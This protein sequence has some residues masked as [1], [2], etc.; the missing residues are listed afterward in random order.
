MTP[1]AS[2][3]KFAVWGQPIAHTLS[4]RIH[5]A[6][7]RARG[8]AYGYAA[9][10][11]APDGVGEACRRARAELRGVNV[12]RPL[13][14]VVMSCL[15]GV[16]EEAGLLG[17]VNVLFFRE[18]RLLGANTDGKGF[19]D[20]LGED[21]R[22]MRVLILGSGGAARAVGQALVG[23]GAR[24]TVAARRPQSV[25]WSLPPGQVLPWEQRN[26][27]GGP[28]DGVVQA[29]PLGQHPGPAVNPFEA[30]A[31]IVPGGFAMDLVYR[32]RLTPFLA[33]AAQAG[34][35]TVDG[36]WM[37]AYQAARSWGYWL[38]EDGPAEVMRQAALAALEEPAGMKSP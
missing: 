34:L 36:V 6:A 37:L 27:P 5:E 9:W 17:A 14:Q 11:V 33:A 32:P 35:R 10:E 18:G 12:T 13:K 21:P 25:E 2:S 16:T 23:A 29:T 4:P 7:F 3:V 15:D 1:A 26:R 22:G 31:T 8:L 38:G 19:L 24:V 28:Y 20:A 30:F